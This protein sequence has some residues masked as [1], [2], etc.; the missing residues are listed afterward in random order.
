M[1]AD[2]RIDADAVHVVFVGGSYR[3]ESTNKKLLNGGQGC[4][5]F[6]CGVQLLQDTSSDN[7]WNALNGK[8]DSPS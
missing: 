3:S 8:K 5:A 7:L 4:A 2:G 6:D 1:T